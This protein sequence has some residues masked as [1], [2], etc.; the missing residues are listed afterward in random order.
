[1]AYLDDFL[2]FDGVPGEGRELI[3]GA[4]A[5]AKPELIPLIE[6]VNNPRNSQSQLSFADCR[7]VE[8]DI[9]QRLEKVVGLET[10]LVT[11]DE[12]NI[13]DCDKANS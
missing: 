13:S 1:M 9:I 2:D 3:M 6:F 7:Q 5:K 8:Q 11:I 12:F 10:S 4:L